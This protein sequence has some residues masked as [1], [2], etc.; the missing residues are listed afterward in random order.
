[1][2]EDQNAYAAIKQAIAKQRAKTDAD[3]KKAAKSK[4]KTAQA[5]S[6]ADGHP[7]IAS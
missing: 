5:K 6:E 3:D 7:V 1:M 2:S 4:G